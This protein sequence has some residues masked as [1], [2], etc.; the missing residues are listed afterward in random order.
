MQ[1]GGEHR[2]SQ[3][4]PDQRES[5]FH[6]VSTTYTAGGID[7]GVTSCGFAASAI[8]HNAKAMIAPAMTSG[9][10]DG[11]SIPSI[12]RSTSRAPISAPR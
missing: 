11:E 6:G 5:P 4:E 12:T 2:E 8:T 7:D 3:A 10:H 1:I 9:A